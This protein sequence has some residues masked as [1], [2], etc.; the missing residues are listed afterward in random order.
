MVLPSDATLRLIKWLASLD[1]DG[2]L[3]LARRRGLRP[4]DLA[5][6]TTLAL[7][8]DDDANISATIQALPRP[9]LLALTML[10]E[11]EQVTGDVSEAARLGLVDDTSSEPHLLCRVDQVSHISVSDTAAPEATRSR[12]GFDQALLARAGSHV[13]TLLC[14]VDDLLGYIQRW[15]VPINKD[16]VLSVS[17]HKMLQESLGD[18]IDLAVLTRFVVGAGIV[19]RHGS[20]L[21]LATDAPWSALSR[22]EQW[23]LL[24]ES[25]WAT[26]PPWVHTLCAD[27][28]ESEWVVDLP[29]LIAHHYPLLGTRADLVALRKEAHA[30]GVLSEGLPTAWG[31]SLWLDSTADVLEAALPEAV[32]GVYANEDFTFL[33]PGPLSRAHRGILDRLTVKEHGGLV[34][35]YRLSAHSIIE[36]LQSQDQDMDMVQALQSTAQNPLPQGMVHLVED[37]I[38]HARNIQLQSHGKGT[39][40]VLGSSQ[41]AKELLA[42]PAL[43][44]LTMS[45]SGDQ[46]LSTTWP[47]ERVHSA[48]ASARYVA[49][50]TDRPAQPAVTHDSTTTPDALRLAVEKLVHSIEGAEK[51]GIAP[52]LGSMIEVATEHK[53]PLE[54]ECEMPGG[55]ITTL[56]MEPRSLSNGRLRGLELKNAMEK[57][58][59]VSCIR[60]ITPWIP[61][62]DTQ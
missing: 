5:S 28:P 53:I 26:L 52:W 56:I 37:T 60:R 18:D 32:P 35:R 43:S 15:P 4:N 39:R 44:A 48:L 17:S 49:L 23:T 61:G 21:H 7:A 34:P 1:H 46:Q 59:P 25:W 19:T 29:A 22:V 10:A 51:L 14:V 62:I 20:T 16:G 3:H 40:V 13:E 47:I 33:A 6:L 9:A 8:L 58:L 24:A 36:A 42:D 50:M 2:L 38:R 27:Y 11:G 41:L 45:A 54:I 12:P 30:L 57:T 31:Q 55:A